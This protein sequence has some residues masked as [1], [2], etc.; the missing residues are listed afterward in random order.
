MENHCAACG[1]NHI[2]KMW[3]MGKVDKIYCQVCGITTNSDGTLSL[4]PIKES[5]TVSLWCVDC[6]SITPHPQDSPTVCLVCYFRGFRMEEHNKAI[7]PK[8]EPPKRRLEID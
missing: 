5:P 4:E 2:L 3:W 1:S 6:N 7:K 8:P